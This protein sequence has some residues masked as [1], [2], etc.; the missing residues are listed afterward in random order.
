M[1]NTPSLT[2]TKLIR[3]PR[4][5]VFEA[6]ITPAIMDR[7]FCPQDLT[8]V[9]SSTDARVGGHFHA[10]MKGPDAVYTV[11]GVYRELVPGKKI[12]FTHR[13]DEPQ[14][15]DTLVTVEF[16]DR[17]GGTEITLTHAQL[18]SQESL[19][20]HE[21]GWRSTLDALARYFAS[22]LAGA[23]ART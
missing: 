21:L 12:V 3:A 16:A 1:T 10:S 5:K 13:W 19:K 9:D 4:D 8:I 2:V 14:A 6:W 18:R 15:V 20:G 11:R 7:W 23:D 22:Q 17:D